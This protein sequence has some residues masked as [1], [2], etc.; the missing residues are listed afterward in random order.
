MRSGSAGR[1]MTFPRGNSMPPA[2]L[3]TAFPPPVEV[4]GLPLTPLTFGQTLDAVDRLLDAGTS[5]FFVT[6]NLHSAMIA[7][8]NPAFAAAVRRAAFVLAD[9]MP[10]VW[11]SR[12]RGRPLPA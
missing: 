9:G 7:A 1:S 8:E 11:A 6:A 3:Q 4:W 10:L 2:A 12:R 5:S